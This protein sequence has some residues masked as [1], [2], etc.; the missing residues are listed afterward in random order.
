[1]TR[2]ARQGT[3]RPRLPPN[4][5]A[6]R[7]L[8]HE[9]ERLRALAE[10]TA[11]NLSSVPQGFHEILRQ[12]ARSCLARSPGCGARR[13]GRCDASR[14][15]HLAQGAC[16]LIPAKPAIACRTASASMMFREGATTHRQLSRRIRGRSCAPVTASAP[17]TAVSSGLASGDDNEAAGFGLLETPDGR[18]FEGEVAPD[19]AGAPKQIRGWTWDLASPATPHHPVAPPAALAGLAGGAA[20]LQKKHRN[21]LQYQRWRDT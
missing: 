17:P 19:D 2:C 10:S 1:M 8:K 20:D 3:P 11:F 12:R 15:S 18:R 21:P 6:S 4:V 14:C 5:R 13:R 9:V 16:Q 7:S